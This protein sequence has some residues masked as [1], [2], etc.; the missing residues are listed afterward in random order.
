MQAFKVDLLDDE[1]QVAEKLSRKY[2]ES[3]VDDI[4]IGGTPLKED[5]IKIIWASI[6]VFANQCVQEE[7]IKT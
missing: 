7:E 2:I 3:I 6:A 1:I 5:Q 4:C